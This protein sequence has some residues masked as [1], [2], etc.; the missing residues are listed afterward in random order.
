MRI[1]PALDALAPAATAIANWACAGITAR[2]Y[3]FVPLAYLQRGFDLH[4]ADTA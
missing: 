4:K 1:P 2:E 3:V